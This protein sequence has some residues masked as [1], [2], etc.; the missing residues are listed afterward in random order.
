[1]TSGPKEPHA[2][3]LP[4][5]TCSFIHP[6]LE[7]GSQQIQKHQQALTKKSPNKSLLQMEQEIQERK[8]SKTESFGY[9]HYIHK[10]HRTN[11]RFHPQTTSGDN[12]PKPQP[13]VS[14][15]A[16]QPGWSLQGGHKTS[17]LQPPPPPHTHM[18]MHTE[19]GCVRN[20]SFHHRLAVGA[21][22]E[23]EVMWGHGGKQ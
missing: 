1:M 19:G 21:L 22:P 11:Q 2:D 20:Q 23:Q 8:T 5:L 15:K 14:E 9:Y 16:G 10:C 18:H 13:V 17:S 7:E 6:S 4:E 3:E 12:T